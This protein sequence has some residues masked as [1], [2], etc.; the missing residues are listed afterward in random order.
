MVS[1]APAIRDTSLAGVESAWLMV[2][3]VDKHE[4]RWRL[5]EMHSRR[6][7]CNLSEQKKDMILGDNAM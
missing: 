1:G 2:A 7:V 6:P 5:G 4:Q 3:H